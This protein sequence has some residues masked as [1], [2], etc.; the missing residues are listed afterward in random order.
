MPDQ[1]ATL[2]S[3]SGDGLVTMKRIS[4]KSLQV[5]WVPGLPATLI[6]ASDDG[7]VAVFDFSD[8]IDEDDSWRAA[9]NLDGSHQAVS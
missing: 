7:L 3:A 2:I 5:I 4:I 9:L 8:E 1:P 6:S